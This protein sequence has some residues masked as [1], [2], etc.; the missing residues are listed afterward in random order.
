ML[1]VIF[2]WNDFSFCFSDMN[3]V[4]SA[5]TPT[6]NQD[7]TNPWKVPNLELYHVWLCPECGFK[8]QTQAL[9]VHHAVL[10]HP[11]AREVFQVSNLT[12]F[13]ST[14]GPLPVQFW[15][16]SG[17]VLAH[18][19]PTSDPLMVHFRSTSGPLP[20]HFRFTSGSLPVQMSNPAPFGPPCCTSASSG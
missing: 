18:F 11:Q 20:V 14:S 10:Q 8:C 9:L 5:T 3:G 16:T 12:H 7:S 6:K 4:V 2:L 19:R 1:L 13:Q 15:P 17:P